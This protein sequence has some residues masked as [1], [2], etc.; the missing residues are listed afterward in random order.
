[1]WAL[2]QYWPFNSSTIRYKQLDQEA[3]ATK[4]ERERPIISFQNYEWLKLLII[5]F[6]I[7]LAAILGFEV[8]RHS[9]QYKASNF[10]TGAFKGEKEVVHRRRD[11]L[12]A[13]WAVPIGNSKATFRYNTSFAAPPPPGGGEEP[14]WDS[15]IPSMESRSVH[16]RKL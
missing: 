10:Q 16:R 1:M 15:L 11:Q 5:V 12:T 4:E 6:L 2:L 9:P 3:A 7:A 14:T 13:C 8:G